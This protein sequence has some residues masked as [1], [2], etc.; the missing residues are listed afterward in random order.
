MEMIFRDDSNHL[1]KQNHLPF[2]ETIL[3]MIQRKEDDLENTF[4]N[5]DGRTQYLILVPTDSTFLS[6]SGQLQL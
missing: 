1:E 6:S 5:M 3:E 2:L 4:R